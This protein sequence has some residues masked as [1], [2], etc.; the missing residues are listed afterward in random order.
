LLMARIWPYD[1]AEMLKAV[2]VAGREPKPYLGGSVWSES[3]VALWAQRLAPPHPN[4][5]LGQ[6]VVRKHYYT[7][8][9]GTNNAEMRLRFG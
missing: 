5:I 6:T 7:S 3:G 2:V 1:N 9:Q 4:H 8:V